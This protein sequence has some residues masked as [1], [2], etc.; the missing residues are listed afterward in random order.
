[1]LA[2]LTEN[3]GDTLALTG[4]AACIYGERGNLTSDG[5]WTYTYDTENRLVLASRPGTAVRYPSDVRD[6][7]TSKTYCGNGHGSDCQRSRKHCNGRAAAQCGGGARR[8]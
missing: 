7:R 8:G 6:W 5:V 3:A 2:D 4:G 1:L